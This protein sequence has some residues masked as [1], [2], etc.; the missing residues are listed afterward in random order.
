MNRLSQFTQP[1]GGMNTATNSDSSDMGGGK[2]SGSE[3]LSGGMPC[4][5]EL[6][7]EFVC[8][9]IF[10]FL[11]YFCV[12]AIIPYDDAITAVLGYIKDAIKGFTDFLYTLIPDSVKKKASSL[13]P[14]SIV[15]FFKETLPDIIQKKKEDMMTPLKK[16]LQKIKEDTEKKINKEKKKLKN[17]KDFFSETTL[18][19]NEKY[20]IAKAKISELWEKFKDKILPAI[21]LS[22]I[23]YII[24]LI[25]FKIIPTILKY[26]IS[27]AQ[28]FKQP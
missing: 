4:K 10:T 22:F 23:Y 8:T 3:I 25:F 2:M 16:K 24:W 17:N 7:M 18:Y 28:Q 26:L 20:L 9:F 21:I 11:I 5:F 27:V 15:K 6:T 1:I 19:F 13:F 14:K 12:F